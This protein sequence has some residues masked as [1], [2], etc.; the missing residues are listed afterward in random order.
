MKA[1]FIT[2]VTGQDG[3]YLAEFLLE[4]EYSVYGLARYCSETKH[5]RIDHLKT[6]PEFHLVEGDLTDT[7]RINAIINSFEQ[8]E[9]IEVY[10]LGAQSHVKVSFGQPEY[11]ANVDALSLIHI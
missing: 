2:G 8:Y 1:A 5:S 9:L 7:A 6:N 3:S 10:N 4:K 11:T